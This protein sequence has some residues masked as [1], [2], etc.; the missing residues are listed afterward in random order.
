M[1][2]RSFFW[3]VECLLLANML[4]HVRNSNVELLYYHGFEHEAILFFGIQQISITSRVSYQLAGNRVSKQLHCSCTTTLYT[5]RATFLG[6]R[7]G[8]FM[9]RFTGPKKFS[10]RSSHSYYYIDTFN[11]PSN[12]FSRPRA[13]ESNNS[14]NATDITT[15]ALRNIPK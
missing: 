5:C 6:A 12:S 14:V 2:E 10:D 9:K 4:V 1:N 3:F 7:N 11:R 13:Q 15:A 8:I